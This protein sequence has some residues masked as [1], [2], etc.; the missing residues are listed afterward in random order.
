MH[1]CH[2]PSRE[3][4]CS[5][6]HFYASIGTSH[7]NKSL[8]QDKWQSSSL[9]MLLM[10]LWMTQICLGLHPEGCSHVCR[11][12]V[13]V[14]DP[15]LDRTKTQAASQVISSLEGKNVRT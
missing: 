12:T 4:S 8:K 14:P 1:A 6:K 5:A 10:R 13:M 15:N 3:Q 11:H 9:S 7:W 2:V